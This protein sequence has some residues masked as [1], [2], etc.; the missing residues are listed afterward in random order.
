M[1]SSPWYKDG[2]RFKCTECGKCC[3]GSAGY[4]WITLD[5]MQK[6]AQSLDISLELFKKRYTRIRD[7]KFALVEKKSKIKEGEYECIFLKDKKCEVYQNRPAQCQTFPW[8][9]SNLNTPE[10][11]KI[12]ALDCEGINDNAPVV[13]YSQILQLL[14]KN[15]D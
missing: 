3:T 1:E 12:A 10:S 4:V 11:W 8:W 6:M 9:K 5:E 14:Q 15:S 7:N 2:L 13:P